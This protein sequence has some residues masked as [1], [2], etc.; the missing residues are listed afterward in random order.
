GGHDCRAGKD[1]SDRRATRLASSQKSPGDRDEQRA[2]HEQGPRTHDG[3]GRDRIGRDRLRAGRDGPECRHEG[4]KDDADARGKELGGGRRRHVGGSV[5]RRFPT[6]VCELAGLSGVRWPTGH[7]S[8][9][10]VIRLATNAAPS[11]A[12][13]EGGAGCASTSS[14]AARHRPANRSAWLMNVV[15]RWRCMA[16]TT[17]SYSRKMPR[18]V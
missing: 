6:R 17:T 4:A 15:R 10:D 18:E 16:S 2:E 1:H 9:I 12:I 13:D 11:V 3:Y 7:P 5:S 8:S 14:I